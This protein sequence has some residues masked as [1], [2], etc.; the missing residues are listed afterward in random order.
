MGLS[1]VSLTCLQDLLENLEEL[2][3]GQSSD[4]L[5]IIGK[6]LQLSIGS[7]I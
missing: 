2:N 3:E 4:I 7:Y 5:P 1:S 6:Y